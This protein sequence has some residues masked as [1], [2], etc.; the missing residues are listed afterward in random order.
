MHSSPSR[1]LFPLPPFATSAH[2]GLV[3]PSLTAP[4]VYN[5]YSV[6]YSIPLSNHEASEPDI[7]VDSRSP[8]GRISRTDPSIPRPYVTASSTR[9]ARTEVS[10]IQSRTTPH[11]GPCTWALERFCQRQGLDHRGAYRKG[12]IPILLLSL[13]DSFIAAL[14]LHPT[15][16]LCPGRSPMASSAG[17]EPT[18]DIQTRMSVSVVR[19]QGI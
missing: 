3:T 12:S 9:N 15:V 1:A 16:N 19:G 5:N 13:H 11:L 10:H 18:V 6:N 17:L 14:H 8:P 7:R 2:L 4:V